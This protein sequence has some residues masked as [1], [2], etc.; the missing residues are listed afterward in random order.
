MTIPIDPSQQELLSRSSINPIFLV[1]ICSTS[2]SLFFC[3]DD[4]IAY[5]GNVY[6]PY[7]AS[8]GTLRTAASFPE[9]QTTGKELQLQFENAPAELNGAHYAHLLQ[10]HE[11]QHQFQRADDDGLQ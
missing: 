5:L 1:R 10:L 2:G 3:T 4:A 11:E 8:V 7:L 6:Q 9:N